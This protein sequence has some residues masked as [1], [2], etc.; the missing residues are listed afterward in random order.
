MGVRELVRRILCLKL[1]L[2]AAAAPLLVASLLAR[3]YTD[4][5]RVAPQLQPVRVTDAAT[6]ESLFDGYGYNWPPQQMVPPLAIKQFPADLQSL[7]SSRRKSLFFRALLPMVE[8]ENAR[9]RAQR[10]FIQERFAQGQLREGSR[11]WSQVGK[12]A[13]IYRV[14]GDINDPQVR[15]I[16]LRR[17]D[18]VPPA[19]MLAQAANESAWGNSR[20]AREANNLFGQWTY[21]QELGMVPARREEGA[22]HYVRVFP[23]LRSSVRAYLRNINIGH[24]YLDLRRM[25]ARM[26][27]AGEPLDPFRLSNGLL[28]YSQRG[29]EYVNDIRTMM[30]V[31]GLDQLGQ[32]Q[33]A[34]PQES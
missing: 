2:V 6:L 31:N 10:R 26:R 30:S 23:D 15:A 32:L 17:V 3:P 29:E 11:A 7:D 8:A 19:L 25:R 9:V 1:R 33:L 28:R 24:A 4:G 18:E 27:A 21:K 20:F 16:L 5:W 14:S 22:R 12:L 34:P 13:E